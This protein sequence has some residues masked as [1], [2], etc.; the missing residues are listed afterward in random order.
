MTTPAIAPGSTARLVAPYLERARGRLV[1]VVRRAAQHSIV[2]GRGYWCDGPA[3]VV[4]GTVPNDCGVIH[5]G[6]RVVGD[7]C[8]QA[9]QP[10]EER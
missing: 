9:V 8:L 3:W 10:K 5:R 6:L 1:R 4:K 2:D 7:H